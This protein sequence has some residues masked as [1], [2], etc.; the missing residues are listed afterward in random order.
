MKEQIIKLAEFPA[1]AG[2]EGKLAE[3]LLTL[4]KDNAD[5]T[6]IDALG[7][8]IARKNGSGPHVLLT[9]HMDE[10]GIVIMHIEEK[11]FSRF[12]ITGALAPNQL[13]GRQVLFTNG[14]RGVIQAEDSKEPPTL[15]KLYIDI[16]ADSE[17]AAKEQVYI[18]LAGVIPDNVIELGN[19]LLSGRALDNRVGCAIALE[20]FKQV[21]KAG[22][23]ITLAFT[24]QET[25]GSRGAK[26][27]A[28]EVQPDW[29]LVIDGVAAGDAPGAKRMEVKLGAGP[30]I[31][32]MDKTALVPIS[33]KNHLVESA[34]AESI[35]IQFEVWPEG[36]SDIG[37]I[38][39]SRGGIAIGGISYPT[40]Y[41]DSTNPT[42]HQGDIDACVKLAVKAILAKS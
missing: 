12:V 28:H 3:H 36:S 20:V 33:I 6:Y 21:A 11:G 5:E 13:V 7:N 23:A 34:K 37:A 1:P 29:A 4:A 2:S 25:V 18:G 9:A 27:V 41:A 19:E 38:Q 31:K 35:E 17:K 26:V 14:V 8:V 16:G 39:R 30:A 10:P 15:D 24:A 42:V 22:R 40:R 32:V